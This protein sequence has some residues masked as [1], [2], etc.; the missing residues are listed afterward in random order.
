MSKKNVKEL[1]EAMRCS[2]KTDNHKCKR[3]KCPY[4]YVVPKDD[5]E[6]QKFEKE[7]QEFAAIAREEFWEQCDFDRMTL[8]AIEI[9][10]RTLE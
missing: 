5:P 6:R 3:E 7:N 10:E 1:I 8:D 4:F 2:L 9:L